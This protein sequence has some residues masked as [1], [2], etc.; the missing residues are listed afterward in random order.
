MNYY[1]IIARIKDRAKLIG[2]IREFSFADYVQVY[3]TVW[4]SLRK[5]Y[6]EKEILDVKI[7]WL[8]EDCD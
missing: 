1:K 4:A 5:Y 8:P 3:Y 6:E 7:Q 2:G